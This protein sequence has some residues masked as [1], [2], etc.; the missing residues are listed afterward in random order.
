MRDG[1]AGD[2]DIADGET[3]AGLEQFEV[4]RNFIPGDGGRG[5]ARDINRDTEL[6]GDDLKARD[7]V[8]M[9]VSDENRGERFRIVTAGA[10]TKQ[11]F[12]AGESSVDEETSPLSSNQ[13]GVA[14][15]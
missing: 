15:A 8:G 13:R 10:K 1:E 5:E 2:I 3:G 11:R 9:F 4:R 14:G 12:L 7:V 6:A